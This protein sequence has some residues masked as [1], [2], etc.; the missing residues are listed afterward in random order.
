MTFWANNATTSTAP[1]ILKIGSCGRQAGNHADSIYT[2]RES[3]GMDLHAKSLEQFQDPRREALMVWVV[4]KQEVAIIAGGDDVI[5]TI[6][7][8]DPQRKRHLRN[9]LQTQQSVK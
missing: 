9:R 8:K 6:G 2:G 5:P 4:P 7:H 3:A 1:P